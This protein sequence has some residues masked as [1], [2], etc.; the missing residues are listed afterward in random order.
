MDRFGWS[1]C[2]SGRVTWQAWGLGFNV[3]FLD[4]KMVKV[5]GGF[6]TFNGLVCKGGLKQVFG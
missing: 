3:V 6:I 5:H 2:K 1:M 4:S